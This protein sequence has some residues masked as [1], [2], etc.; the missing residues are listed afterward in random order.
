MKLTPV[1]CCI[2]C[3]DVPR[4]VLRRLELDFHSEPLKQ[5]AQVLN[6]VE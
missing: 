4:M 3:S 6:Q 1:H 5:A 2:I